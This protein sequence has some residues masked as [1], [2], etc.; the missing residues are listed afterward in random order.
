MAAAV[1]AGKGAGCLVSVGSGTITDLGKLASHQTGV[2]L[3]AVPTAASV[4]GYSDHLAVVLRAGAKRTVPAASPA[5]LV[6][7]HRVLAG[8]PVAMGRAGLGEC[9]GAIVAPADWS[10]AADDRRRPDLRRRDRQELPPPG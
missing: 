2:P 9:V 5:A 4:N 3:V 8:A 1:A 7:D 6:V 10:L